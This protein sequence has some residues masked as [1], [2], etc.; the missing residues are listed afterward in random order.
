MMMMID[1]LTRT[2]SGIRCT[3]NC[4]YVFFFPFLFFWQQLI[5]QLLRSFNNTFILVF[6]QKVL[7]KFYQLIPVQKIKRIRDRHSNCHC[8]LV[9]YSCQTCCYNMHAPVCWLVTWT[10]SWGYL[11]TIKVNSYMKTIA[12]VT[13]PVLINCGTQTE[14]CKI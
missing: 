8:I 4:I 5:K 7:G 1:C 10:V 9:L 6:V 12:T 13:S 11:A 3:C 14:A 2:S